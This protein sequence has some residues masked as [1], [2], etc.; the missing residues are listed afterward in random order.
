MTYTSAHVQACERLANEAKDNARS[1]TNAD[2]KTYWSA[3]YRHWTN[4]AAH[5]VRSA[6]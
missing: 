2:S 4:R 6:I 1:A 3:Q 5:Y